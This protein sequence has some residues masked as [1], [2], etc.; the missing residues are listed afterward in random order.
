MRLLGNGFDQQIRWLRFVN[1]G[2]LIW[3]RSHLSTSID[4]DTV[5]FEME[6]FP[7]SFRSLAHDQPGGALLCFENSKSDLKFQPVLVKV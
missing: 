6:R 7:A 3:I 4:V 1:S 2:M 5:R